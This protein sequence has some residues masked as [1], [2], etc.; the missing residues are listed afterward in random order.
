M[1]TNKESIKIA[2]K[3]EALWTRVKETANQRMQVL[4]DDLEVNK[5]VIKLAD[6]IIEEEKK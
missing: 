6:K 4:E 1:K 5:E 2:T 3:K